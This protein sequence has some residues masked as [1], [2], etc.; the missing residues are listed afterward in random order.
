MNPARH[1][2]APRA[3]RARRRA[4]RR[5]LRVTASRCARSRASRCPPS[6][7][8]P[9]PVR[10]PRSRLTTAILASSRPPST[11]FMS[12]WNWSRGPTP[13]RR[14]GGKA[15]QTYS[16]PAVPRTMRPTTV[17]DSPASCSSVEARAASAA[18][19]ATISPSPMLNA[20]YIS[21]SATRP[22]ALHHE[23]HRE[24]RPGVR[25]RSAPRSLRRQDAR[26]VVGEAAAGDVG[27]PVT[28]RLPSS[29]RA[30]RDRS[31]AARAAP[32]RSFRRARRRAS[33]R[34]RALE[35]DLRASE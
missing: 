27:Q 18:A 33:S 24:H 15:P 12:A 30:A 8:G 9:R 31:G 26:Q 6:R 7:P 5:R 20:R 2:A 23:E 34:A 10:R 22:I 11:A 29:G 25:A 28:S 14:C 16:T 1:T 19:T 17:G 35:E 13:A 21:S 3:R 32:R 4:A